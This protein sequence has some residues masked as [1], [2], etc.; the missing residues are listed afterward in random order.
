[1]GR[2]LLERLKTG[3][4]KLTQ[5]SKWCVNIPTPDGYAA[6]AARGRRR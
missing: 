3:P 1:M 2:Q 4:D 5:S 6:E